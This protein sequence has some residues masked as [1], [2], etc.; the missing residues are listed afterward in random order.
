MASDVKRE[1]TFAAEIGRQDGPFDN[2]EG[3]DKYKLFNKLTLPLTPTSS[4]TIGESSYAGNWH[5]S[6]QIPARAVDQGLVSR[7]G[8]IDPSEGGNTA[9]HQLFLIYKLRPSETTE[10]NAVAYAGTYRF[11]LFSDFTLYARDPVD[12]D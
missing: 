10:L 12:G 3:W 5:G 2:P 11:N 6:G 8:S 9:R 1:A 4:L 7:F